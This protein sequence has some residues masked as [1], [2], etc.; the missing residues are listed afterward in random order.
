[1]ENDK[2]GFFGEVKETVEKYIQDRLLLFKLEASERVA[3][4]VS[5][6]YILL[7][8]TFLLLII[9]VLF[10]FLAG[11]YL[12]VWLG[13]YWMGFGIMLLLY[14]GL[15]VLLIYLHKKR[16]KEMVANKVIQSIF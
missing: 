4:L 16:I 15:C 8:L 14:I 9:V 12:S 10:T 11:Y 13:A 6:L 1:M 7:P 3:E 2:P 5:N